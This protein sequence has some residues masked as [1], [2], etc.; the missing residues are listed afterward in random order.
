[1]TPHWH[2]KKAS[3]WEREKLV[4]KSNSMSSWYKFQPYLTAIQNGLM[5][6]NAVEA[7]VPFRSDGFRDLRQNR[8]SITRLIYIV[9]RECTGQAIRWLHSDTSINGRQRM[10]ACRTIPSGLKFP[11]D[12]QRHCDI[13]E[14]GIHHLDRAWGVCFN[15]V[16][17]REGCSDASPVSHSRLSIPPTFSLAWKAN[18]KRHPGLEVLIT[19]FLIQPLRNV[20]LRPQNGNTCSKSQVGKTNHSLRAR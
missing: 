14:R 15:G 18:P 1:M 19:I 5:R 20:V 4:G 12:G 2:N 8:P 6:T 7:L 10:R 3:P 13:R 17:V 9:E 11:L 16:P